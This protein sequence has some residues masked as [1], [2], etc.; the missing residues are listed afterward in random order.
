MLDRLH[1]IQYSQLCNCYL[2]MV[3]WSLTVHGGASEEAFAPN[4]NSILNIIY[5]CWFVTR[6]CVSQLQVMSLIPAC[7]EVCLMLVIMYDRLL[8][9]SMF[10]QDTLE[11]TSSKTEHHNI[12]EIL[13]KVVLNT[14][15]QL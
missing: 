14:I 1:V 6:Q 8:I 12:P 9:T 13:L 7:G 3:I 15:T 10:S 5:Y 11:S 4:G 2:V